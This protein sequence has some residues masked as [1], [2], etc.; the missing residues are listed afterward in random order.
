MASHTLNVHSSYNINNYGYSQLSSAASAG[1]WR[2]PHNSEMIITDNS[3]GQQYRMYI[4]IPMQEVLK[5]NKNYKITNINLTLDAYSG[6]NSPVAIQDVYLLNSI[7]GYHLGSNT[8]SSGKIGTINITKA[9]SQSINISCSLTSESFSTDMYLLF[10]KSSSSSAAAYKQVTCTSTNY[11]KVTLTY[12]DPYTITYNANGGTGA[13]SAGTKI[14]NNSFTISNTKPTKANGS[15]TY[16]ITLDGN[17]GTLSPTSLNQT[18]TI[19]YTFSHWNT[20]SDDSGTK[21]NAGATY[22]TNS[23]LTLYAQYTSTL[24]KGSVILQVNSSVKDSVEQ[25]GFVV[26]FDPEGGSNTP[27]SK[28][29]KRTASYSLSGWKNNASGT[30][31]AIG[32]EV[33]F[34][35]NTTLHAQWSTSY[36]EKPINISETAGNKEGYTYKGWSTIPST[37][38]TRPLIDN[39]NF[40][41]TSNITLYA[42]WE[43]NIY[44]VILDANDGYFEDN[45]SITQKEVSIAYGDTYKIIFDTENLPRRQDKELELWLTEDN[46]PITSTT[47][48]LTADKH[49]LYA[50]W[51]SSFYIVPYMYYAGQWIEIG[52][53]PVLTVTDT[54]SDGD[55]EI[56]T[57]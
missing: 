48:M 15:S 11:P 50:K 10:I 1:G 41:T 55:I 19:K 13:P 24:T 22:T 25:D 29:T 12:Y 35:G 7:Q 53:T 51:I 17:G 45:P 9:N 28:T 20:K 14:Y 57:S 18:D 32:Q 16:T 21:Y 43:A 37:Q 8:P 2:P 39:E 3:S 49:T 4:K 26:I 52:S 40:V 5:N 31:F 23:N 56:T 36:E 27:A 38:E 6:S 34:S 44:T 54:T 47:L 30:I 33:S 42:V 46:Q